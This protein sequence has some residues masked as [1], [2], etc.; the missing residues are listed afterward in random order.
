MCGDPELREFGAVTGREA[1]VLGARS[2]GADFD[3]RS[4]P[5]VSSFARADNAVALPNA[6]SQ[7][8]LLLHSPAPGFISA[9]G[10]WLL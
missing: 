2:I 10:G 4:F 3:P 7:A 6:L 1:G 8:L 5:P 9:D